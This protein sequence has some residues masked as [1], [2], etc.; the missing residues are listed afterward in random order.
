MMRV[1]EGYH[2]SRWTF[3]SCE[4][5]NKVF[6]SQS[7]KNLCQQHLLISIR[8][9]FSRGNNR[10]DKT[11]AISI[12]VHRKSKYYEMVGGCN[13]IWKNKYLI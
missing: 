10:V 9:K 3:P 12:Y 11:Q 13:T 2:S 5:H 6:L 8:Q 7:V 4:T 1:R